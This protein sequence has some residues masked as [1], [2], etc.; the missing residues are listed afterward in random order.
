MMAVCPDDDSGLSGATMERPALQ[1][2]MA[3]IDEGLV[4]A[5]VVY[6]VDRLTR[7]LADFAKMV[8][9][10]DARGVSFRRRDPAVQ[11]HDF[12]LEKGLMNRR[13]FL[14]A[15]GSAALLPILPRRLSAS[16]NFRRRRPS[17][18]TWP[19]QSAYGVPGNSG[20]PGTRL[21]PR[22]CLPG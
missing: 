18:A 8:E 10:V 14:K 15:I 20:R 7:S 19:S 1:R 5:V 4:D 3:D 11:Y 16:T 21:T 2:L 13:A 12:V 17:D 22:R 9:L 6:K